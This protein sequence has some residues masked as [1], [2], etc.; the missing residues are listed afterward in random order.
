MMNVKGSLAR[1]QREHNAIYRAI[2]DRDEAAARRAAV[3][4]LTHAASRMSFTLG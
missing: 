3:N 2:R 1:V 4:H